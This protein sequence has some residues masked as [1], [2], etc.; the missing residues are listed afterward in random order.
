[1]EKTPPL[2]VPVTPEG[3]PLTEA[4]VALPPMLYVIGAM[5][6]LR[7]RSW[8]VV[9]EA[10]VRPMLPFGITVMVPVAAALPQPPVSVTV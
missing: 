5:E 6:E 3:R 8:E 1:M 4:P 7:Q 10:E 2:K 9:E